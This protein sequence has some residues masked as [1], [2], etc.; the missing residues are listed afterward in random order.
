MASLPP[1]RGA[2]PVGA[3][4]APALLSPFCPDAT[5]LHLEVWGVCER[6]C[7]AHTPRR[8]RRSRARHGGHTPFVQRSHASNG[9]IGC[10]L[11]QPGA[12]YI[13]TPGEACAHGPHPMTRASQPGAPSWDWSSGR[14]ACE[15]P[16]PLDTLDT[17]QENRLQERWARVCVDTRRKP[18]RTGRAW[19]C[20]RPRQTLVEHGGARQYDGLDTTD[21]DTPGVVHHGLATRASGRGLPAAAPLSGGGGPPPPVRGADPGSPNA[22]LY[23]Q[24][25]GRL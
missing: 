5:T 2:R 4:H 7:A 9:W 3:T 12:S 17:I 24:A 14:G 22:A 10:H 11:W 19:G 23:C 16:G 18:A 15:P 25:L 1:D 8:V 20:G 6:S 13:P 21:G